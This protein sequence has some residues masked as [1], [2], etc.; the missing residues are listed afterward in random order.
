[1]YATDLITAIMSEP[2]WAPHDPT[3]ASDERKGVIRLGYIRKGQSVLVKPQLVKK[4]SCLE[5]WYELLSGGFVCGKYGTL[6]PNDNALATRRPVP[7]AEGPLPYEYGLNLT[8]GTPLYRRPPLR[9]ERAQYER[10]L[11]IGKKQVPIYSDTAPSAPVT[12]ADGTTPWYL[13][14]H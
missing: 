12:N 1:M 14:D 6:D 8:N 4:Q 3:K 2:E 11:A 7:L 5:G 10:A 13:Q 9:K